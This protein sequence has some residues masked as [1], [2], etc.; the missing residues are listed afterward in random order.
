MTWEPSTV[1]QHMFKNVLKAKE[2]VY[3]EE[4]DPILFC[5]SVQMSTCPTIK[6]LQTAK[7]LA[8]DSIAQNSKWHSKDYEICLS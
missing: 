8:L 2:E 5:Y 3:S 1:Y 4:I 7:K 6:L